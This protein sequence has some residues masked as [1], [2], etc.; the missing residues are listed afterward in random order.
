MLPKVTIYITNFNYGKFIS[1]AIDS[2]IKQTFKSIEIIIIDDG[3]TDNSKKI[4]TDYASKN[5]NIRTKFTKNNGLIKTCNT[6]LSLARGEFIL[7]LDADDWLDKNAIEIM[8]NKMNSNKN[9]E[10]VFPD[11]YEVDIYGH[12]LHSIRRHDFEKIK[13]LDTPAH[14]ACALFRTKT[15]VLNGGYD[16]NFNCQDGVDIWL[17]YFRKFKV[18]NINIPLFYYRKHGESLSDNKNKILTNKNKIL[19][20]NNIIHDSNVVAFL[21]L[22][23]PK[24]D[25]Y[26]L[27]FTKIGKKYLVDWTVENILNVKQVDYLII[28]SPDNNVLNYFKNKKIKKI[29][30]LKRDSLK[31]AQ[32]VS[33]NDSVVE[34]I[35]YLKK[36]LSYKTNYVL[37]SKYNC[38]FRNFKHLENAI[39][40][41]QIFNLD[42]V[43]GVSNEN[44]IFFRHTGNTLKP[45]RNF[46]LFTINNTKK[47]K[48]KI[49]N[50][51]IFMESGNFSVYKADYLLK[52]N[53]YS[54]KIGSEMLGNLSRF[55]IKGEF[56]L[57]LAKQI[58]KNYDKFDSFF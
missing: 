15:L 37:I 33:I 45:L 7:R 35:N 51:E 19:F 29:V 14:G 49:E 3:S 1:K 13:L 9:I 16:E 50:E 25:K 17:R 34:G 20:K 47:I 21:P 31:S 5:S 28:S 52:E 27:I 23:G 44:H 39:N 58:A 11:Y 2:A 54:P 18:Y 42:L 36:K 8:V 57:L 46:D 56:E 26:S 55:E 32:S 4:I 10:I 22:R 53:A 30:T 41:I 12:V 43:Y 48:V 40:T 6:A 24:F 38:P